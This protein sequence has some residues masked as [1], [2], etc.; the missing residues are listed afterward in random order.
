MPRVSIFATMNFLFPAFLAALGVITIPILLHLFHLRRFKTFYFS[1]LSFVKALDVKSKSARKIKNFLILLARILALVSLVLAF[2]QPYWNKNQN[3][4][5][6]KPEVRILFIDNTFSMTSMGVEGELLAQARSMAKELISKD[7]IGSKFLILSNFFAGEEM[8]LLGQADALDYID[9]LPMAPFPKKADVI[10]ERVKDLMQQLNVQ[11]TLFVLSDGQINQWQPQRKLKLDYSIRFVQ[12][13]PENNTNLSIDSIWTNVPVMR[14]GAQFD[15]FVKIRNN[16]PTQVKAASMSLRMHEN[17]QM[18]NVE[19]NGERSKV[20]NLSYITP[21]KHG[22]YR[23]EAEIEDNQIHFDDVLSA[24]F[25]V[26]DKMQT[27]IINGSDA[28]RNVEFVYTLDDYYQVQL[29]QQN[30][31]N[32]SAIGTVELLVLNQVTQ[33]DGGLKNRVMDHVKDGKAVVLVPHPKSDLNSWNELLADL[34]M[35]MLQKSDSGTVFINKIGVEN[36]FFNGLFDSPNPKIQI[37]VKRKTRL[38]SSGSK[39]NPLISFSDGTPFLCR[40]SSPKKNIFLFNADLHKGNANILTSDLFSTLFLR[41][42]EVAGSIQPLFAFLGEPSELRFKVEKFNGDRPAVMRLKEKEFIPR[43]DFN[44]GVLSLVLSGRAE[45]LILDAGYYEVYSE[46]QIIGMT[47]LNFPRTESEL[48]YY[49]PEVF[50]RVMREKGVEK[51]SV[52]QVSE[53]YEIEK[54]RSTLDGGLWRVF[55]VIAILFFLV[56]M[57]LVKFWK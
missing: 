43:Q 46:N 26:A 30:Q 48:A 55:L 13:K 42:G 34:Q 39:S 12:L 25:Q 10:Y 8:R 7:P 22:F 36:S 21:R 18:V 37:P 9:A 38:I 1:N 49:N 24:V 56:E 52:L 5:A 27:G 54:M 32:L 4:V 19:F 23:V 44:N 41:I 28:G 17:E 20:V 6:S 47:A 45:E 35:P 57:L 40:S 3:Q 15:L 11:G 14:P 53:S 31:V 50:T 29:W 2:A 33:I 51:F 16:N